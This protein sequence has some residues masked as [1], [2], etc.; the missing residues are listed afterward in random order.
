MLSCIK[1][2]KRNTLKLCEFCIQTSHIIYIVAMD[3]MLT[4]TTTRR[5]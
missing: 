4:L 2:V 3:T 1:P 5:P